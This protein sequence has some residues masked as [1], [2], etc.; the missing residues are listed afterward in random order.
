MTIISEPD[1]TPAA[2]LRLWDDYQPTPLLD[3]PRLADRC[4]VARVLVKAENSRP[5][6]NFKSL[7][8]LYAG[9]R[10]L[11]RAAGLP[12]I[13]AL[14][15]ANGRRPDLP[16]LVCASDG[17]HGLAVAAAAQRAG[18][19][20]RIFLHEGV[21][22][23]RA[24][25]IAAVGAEIIWVRG[26]YDDAVDQAAGAAA[27]G[28]GLLIADTTDDPD[29]SVVADVMAGYGILASE[30]I[31]QLDAGGLGRPTHLF[32]QAGVGGLAAAMADG[33]ASRLASPRCIVVVEP[34]AAPCVARALAV[35]RPERLSDD[36]KTSAEMLSCGLASAP[37]VR[38]LL[39]HGAR[40]VVVGEDLL[41][42]AAWVM[43]ADGGPPT[44]PS[45]AAGLAGLMAAASSGELRRDLLLNGDAIVLMIATE[46]PIE[47]DR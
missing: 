40:S 22:E 38:T 15:D 14:V 16:T 42:D 34:A 23:A 3:L 43:H 21:S 20:A 8:G 39:R 27:R 24:A 6:G 29:D 1:D 12:G 33:L 46:A 26:T 13:G 19:A 10:A 32:V 47:G 2:L 30:V 28:D 4:G 45:G 7:G 25:R 44:T 36:L 9:L 31:G 17:N 41:A 35:G 5:L 18:A 11:A 37:A